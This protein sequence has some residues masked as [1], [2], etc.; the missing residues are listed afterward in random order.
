MKKGSAVGSLVDRLRLKSGCFRPGQS[1]VDE[2]L[3]SARNDVDKAEEIFR[4]VR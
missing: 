2:K 4:E 1:V 3:E